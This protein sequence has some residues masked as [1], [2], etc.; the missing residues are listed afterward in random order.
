VPSAAAE[1]RG[2]WELW[3]A[4]GWECGVALC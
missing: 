2:E 4:G 3:Y 1:C